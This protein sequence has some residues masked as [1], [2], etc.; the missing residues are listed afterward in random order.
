M[1]IKDIKQVNKGSL[2]LVF[3]I[4]FPQIHSVI[5]DFKLMSGKNGDWIS[6]PSREYQDPDGKKKYFAFFVVDEPFKEQFQKACLD[7]LQPYILAPVPASAAQQSPSASPDDD[8]P[9]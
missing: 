7:L 1:E 3:S 4:S 9:F 6:A 8:I 5:R 2:K